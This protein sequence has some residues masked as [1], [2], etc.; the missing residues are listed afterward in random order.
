MTHL[1]EVR[2]CYRCEEGCFFSRHAQSHQNY[3]TWREFAEEHEDLDLDYNLL[4]R[5]DWEFVDDEG[6]YCG[7]PANPSERT[8]ELKLFFMQ[9][10]KAA[11]WSC[12]V[13]VCPDDETAV[14]EFLQRCFNHLVKLWQ[15]ME[16]QP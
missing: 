6:E 15:P 9:Q 5:W 14:R 13:K 11:P 8:G 2:H 12:K 7:P 16:V 10:R 3:E 4:F 1:W